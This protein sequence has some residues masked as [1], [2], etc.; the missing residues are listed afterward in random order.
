MTYCY[1]IGHIRPAGE[2]FWE[3]RV[4]GPKDTSIPMRRK[5]PGATEEDMFNAAQNWCDKANLEAGMVK[6]GRRE[7]RA[8]TY[9]RLPGKKAPVQST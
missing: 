2:G 8:Y 7:R 6:R 4:E 3:L 9:G 5:T 1:R